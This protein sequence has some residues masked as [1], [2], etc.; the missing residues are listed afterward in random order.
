MC[1]G[2]ATEMNLSIKC[3]LVKQTFYLVNV[4][5]SFSVSMQFCWCQTFALLPRVMARQS[6]TDL[7][8]F[9][10]FFIFYYLLKYSNIIFFNNQT[11]RGTQRERE[12]EKIY[13][14]IKLLNSCP[15]VILDHG[16]SNKILL[17]SLSALK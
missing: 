13:R 6:G 12:K 10:F 4:V 2:Q 1:A 9:Y 17:A 8:V 15:N 14:Q 3:Q 16:S 11:N 7:F 5:F